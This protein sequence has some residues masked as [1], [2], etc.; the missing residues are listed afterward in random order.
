MI[1]TESE[2]PE[3]AN[4]YKSFADTLATSFD[5]VPI[6]MML[7]GYPEKFKRL[8]DHNPSVNRIFHTHELKGLS[9]RE[10]ENFYTTIFFFIWYGC[11]SGC[12]RKNVRVFFWGADNDAGNWRCNFLE[13]Y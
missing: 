10:I 7:T 4:W 3:F 8:Y 2:T 1:L 12:F 11:V 9:N 6:C 13:G 5:N